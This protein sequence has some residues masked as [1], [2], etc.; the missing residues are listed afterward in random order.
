MARSSRFNPRAPRGARPE[1]RRRE[2]STEVVS[3]HAPRVGRDENSHGIRR[4]SKSFQST[5]PAWGATSGQWHL[6][7]S[8]W[9]QSTRPAWGATAHEFS[10][11]AEPIVSIHAPRV[12]RDRDTDP[13]YR[14]RCVSIHAPRVGRDGDRDLFSSSHIVSIHAPRVGR[15]DGQLSVES[16]QLKF[17]STRP[18]WGATSPRRRRWD[19]C[20][21]FNPRA[22]RGARREGVR[23]RGFSNLFQSTRPAWGATNLVEGEAAH[24]ERFQSTRPAWGATS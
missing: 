22:P 18:A 7:P 20:N 9:F 4:S 8:L 12:G 11:R 15:D 19:R 24:P 2:H 13:L 3:I 23:L 5:R 1:M 17:Q 21:S 14:R 6:K 16:G 10:H